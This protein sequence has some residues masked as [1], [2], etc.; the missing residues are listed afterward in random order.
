MIN[1]TVDTQLLQQA[2]KLLQNTPKKLN[3]A[4]RAAMARTLAHMKTRLAQLGS[5]KYYAKSS[6]IK[7]SISVKKGND[8]GQIKSSGTRKTL[9]DY[10][11]SPRKQK[12]RRKQKQLMGA[13]KRNGIKSLG[14]AFY[15]P[16]KGRLLPYVR[17]GKGKWDIKSLISPAIP[18]ILGNIEITEELSSE[19]LKYYNQ[20]LNHEIMRQL[21]VFA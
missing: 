21:G 1:M 5:E 13:V 15:I 19:T 2:V 8:Y 4:Q 12:L 7:R 6:E 11:L 14:K 20:R 3:Q 16:I 18:Q 10:Y 9:A 17:V